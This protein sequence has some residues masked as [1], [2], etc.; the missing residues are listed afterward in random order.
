MLIETA[1]SG[2]GVGLPLGTGVIGWSDTTRNTNCPADQPI[3]PVPNGRP[4][5]TPDQDDCH[6]AKNGAPEG[7]PSHHS[8]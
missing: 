1:W 8:V 2:A 7:A 6:L 3:T 5:P 4:T